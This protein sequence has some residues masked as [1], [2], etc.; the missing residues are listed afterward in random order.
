MEE[1]ICPNFF[2]DPTRDTAVATLKNIKGTMAVSI[3]FRKISPS[4]LMYGVC[5][6]KKK[7][8][9]PP[10]K[11]DDNKSKGNFERRNKDDPIVAV[12]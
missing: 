6:P 3:K 4:G 2:N 9:S 12:R 7:P 1:K 5:S 8:K 10:N 11:S